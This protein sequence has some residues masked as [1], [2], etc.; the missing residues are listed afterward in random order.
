MN[1]FIH[2][3]KGNRTVIYN[4]ITGSNDTVYP[5][6][7]I[8]HPFAE[9]AITDDGLFHIVEEAIRQ[10]GNGK[11]IIAGI[12]D[13]SDLD[14]LVKTMRSLYP[15]EEKEDFRYIDDFCK[16]ILLSETMTLNFEKLMQYYKETGGNPN[17]LI[18]PFIKEYVLPVKSKKEGKII[19]ELIRKQVLG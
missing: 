5:D 12:A 13:D 10:Y 9:E 11:V 3:I 15:D 7:L 4:K 1:Y 17:D 6:I 8:N 16:N 2:T 19:Y 14:Y 18:T